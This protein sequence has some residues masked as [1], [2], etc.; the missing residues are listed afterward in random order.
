MNE[1]DSY[2]FYC[3]ECRNVVQVTVTNRNRFVVAHCVGQN[4]PDHLGD[5]PVIGN[6]EKTKM[7]M[8]GTKL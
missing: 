5:E 1:L 2:V 8:I 4:P 3:D 6:H 7:R